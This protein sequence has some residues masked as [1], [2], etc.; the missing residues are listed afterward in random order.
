MNQRIIGIAVAAAG[1]VLAW[2]GW[3][4][5]QS[6]SSGISQLVTGSPSDR[7]LWFLIGGGALLVTGL[8][9]AAGV[10]GPRGRRK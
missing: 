9:L 2:I 10:V 5:K 7:A 3:Q 1:A 6:L 4:E 8:L